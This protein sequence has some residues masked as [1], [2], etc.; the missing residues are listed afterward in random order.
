MLISTLFIRRETTKMFITGGVA[1]YNRQ[2]NPVIHQK[3]QKSNNECEVKCFGFEA[4]LKSNQLDRIK[5]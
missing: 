3:N 1:D 4:A 5:S 2:T